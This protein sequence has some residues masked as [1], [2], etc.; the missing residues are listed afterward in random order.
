MKTKNE[1]LVLSLTIFG[2]ILKI[3]FYISIVIVLFYFYSQLTL[4]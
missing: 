1:K 4:K 2:S 3:V